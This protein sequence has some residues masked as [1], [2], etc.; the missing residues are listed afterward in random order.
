M[1]TELEAIIWCPK[2]AVAKYEVLREPT[3]NE[4]V[5]RN[6]TVPPEKTGVQKCECGANLERKP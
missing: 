5:F 4:G 1:P 2:C 3:G 6:V